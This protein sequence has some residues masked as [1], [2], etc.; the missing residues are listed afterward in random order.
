MYRLKIAKNLLKSLILSSKRNRSSAPADGI[1]WGHCFY[2][3]Q[4]FLQIRKVD[5]SAT[6]ESASN[7]TIFVPLSPM[8]F[9][10]VL[11]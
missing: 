7:R 5:S 3:A 11:G 2:Y 10:L 9:I 6:A 4:V 8:S 1:L